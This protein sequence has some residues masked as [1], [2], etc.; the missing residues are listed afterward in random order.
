M[1]KSRAG[2]PHVFWFVTK[3]EEKYLEFLNTPNLA[4]L[5]LKFNLY[6]VI[7][8]VLILHLHLDSL[9]R[10]D[11]GFNPRDFCKIFLITTHFVFFFLTH[12]S[13]SCAPRPK[14]H[15]LV[16]IWRQRNICWVTI[17]T[18][19]VLMSA[20]ISA[21]LIPLWHP[22]DFSEFIYQY[23][24]Y[25]WNTLRFGLLVVLAVNLRILRLKLP[26][27]LLKQRCLILMIFLEFIPIELCIL[28]HNFIIAVGNISHQLQDPI[29]FE[30]ES[31]SR[32]Y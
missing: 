30:G 26:V 20:V 3:N 15:A 23:F 8:Q 9:V 24:I 10:V 7:L 16:A 18:F 22:I 28:L 21:Q 25:I 1:W 5:V 17:T 2:Y 6:R 27:F 11:I 14:V 12:V 4:T 19:I 31:K 13:G 29:L 32:H